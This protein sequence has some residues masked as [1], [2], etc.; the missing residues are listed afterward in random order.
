MYLGLVLFFITFVVLALSKLLLARLR[1]A[2]GRAHEQRPIRRSHLDAAPRSA[3]APSAPAAQARQRRRADAVAGGDGLRPVLADLDPVRDA[4]PGHR[5]PVALALHRDDAAAQTEAGGL[6]NAI[7]GSLTMVALATLIG[8]PIGILAGI[9]LAEYGQKGWL[10]ERHA[11]HQRHPAVGAVDR[12]RPVHLCG[13][14]GARCKRS[15]ASP[16]SLALALIVIPVVIRTTENML[17]LVPNALREAAYALGTPKWKVI[18][19]ITLKAR[20]R[21]RHHR[22]AAGGGAHRRRDGAAALHRAVATSSGAADMDQ[23]MASLP[24]TIFKFAMSPYENWQQLAW[25]G[26][27]LITARRA[28][29]QHPRARARAQQDL[30]RTTHGHPSRHAPADGDREA[31]LSV[32]NLNFY[33]GKFHALKNINL[34]I[35]ENKVTAFIGPSG[36]G[37]STLLR[38]F[39][40]MFELYPE[41]R[42]EGEILL[43]GENILTLEAGR[44]ADPCQGRHGVPEA[45]AVPDVDLRQHRLRREAVRERCRASRWTSAS[46][47]R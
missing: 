36:C 12:H 46:N 44:G 7:F 3:R 43:D 32:R 14:R 5:R 30:T 41:Q 22:R 31:K 34:D 25:A 2:K 6:A 28:G 27:F 13:G 26:V 24:V 9:Y 33:Y 16:A 40:R 15:R 39:N 29:P 20:D 18:M 38:T 17:Q 1:S 19:T 45:D 35:P 11:L 10:G 23:P 47:G 42:A 37:K 21:R 4:A 8:T